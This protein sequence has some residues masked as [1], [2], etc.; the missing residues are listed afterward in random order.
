MK[1][2]A[3][4]YLWALGSEDSQIIV[5]R[6]ADYRMIQRLEMNSGFV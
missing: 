3:D 1:K 4:S 6:F 2:P 5:R